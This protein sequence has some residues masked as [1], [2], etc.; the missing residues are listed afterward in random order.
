MTKQ[1]LWDELKARG[2]KLD[3]GAQFYTAE[4]LQEMYNATMIPAADEY[5]STQDNTQ[6]NSQDNSSEGFC[7]LE[8]SGCGWCPELGKS[9][10]KGVYIP[11]DRA[12]YEALKKYALREI[13]L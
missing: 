1:E 8:F 5:G 6:D 13:P 2:V 11:A 3:R 9:Y 12:E 7:A 10:S 4:A